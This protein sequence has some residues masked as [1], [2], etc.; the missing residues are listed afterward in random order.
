MKKLIAL[1]VLSALCGACSSTENTEQSLKENSVASLSTS[2]KIDTCPIEEP[3]KSDLINTTW[4]PVYLKDQDKAPMPKGGEDGIVYLR[5]NN[6]LEAN[7]MSGDNL[8]GGSI[9][10]SKNGSFRASQLF[11]TRRMGKFPLYEYKFLQALHKSN[12]IY[13]SSSG[14]TMKLIDGDTVLIKFNKIEHIKD[15]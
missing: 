1:I 13:I 6:K 2:S 9:I 8:F 5:F 11:S 12:R 3:F 7:G 14:K 4:T 15:K 10:I